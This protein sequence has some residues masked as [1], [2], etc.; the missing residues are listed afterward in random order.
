LGP[1]L[2]KRIQDY[3]YKISYE[4]E[5]LFRMRKEIATNNKFKK[6]TNTT[7]IIKSKKII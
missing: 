5:H 4:S 1:S 6:L 3:E 7:N 2:R